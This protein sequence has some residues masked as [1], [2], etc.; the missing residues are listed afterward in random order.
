M[1]KES[2]ITRMLFL[3]INCFMIYGCGQNVEVRNVEFQSID[4]VNKEV[5]DNLKYKYTP[6]TLENTFY[7]ERSIE[8]EKYDY[9]LSIKGDTTFVGLAIRDTVFFVPYLLSNYSR[10]LDFDFNRILNNDS[11]VFL[12]SGG[13]M[14]YY[15]DS[16]NTEYFYG[17]DFQSLFDD[18]VLVGVKKKYIIS[19]FKF[20]NFQLDIDKEYFNRGKAIKLKKYKFLDR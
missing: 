7:V 6:T 3:V 20:G 11:I 13:G 1:K 17:K 8:R 18:S 16:M 14:R 9:Y 10:S 5:D 4:N 2:L 19:S 12:N 15:K